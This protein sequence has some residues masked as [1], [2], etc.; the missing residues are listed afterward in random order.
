M[1]AL[2]AII[3]TFACTVDSV[4]TG[5]KLRTLISTTRGY[6][7]RAL[8]E[9]HSVVDEAKGMFNDQCFSINVRNLLNVDA[10][11]HCSTMEFKRAVCW[12][13]HVVAPLEE[14]LSKEVMD[15][16]IGTMLQAIDSVMELWTQFST[17]EL[18]CDCHRNISKVL[19]LIE[20]LRRIVQAGSA[21]K[22]RRKK[23]WREDFVLSSAEVLEAM[24]SLPNLAGDL[25]RDDISTSIAGVNST[26]S[27]A[28]I[29]SKLT[30][31][32]LLLLE[33]DS[34]LL[35]MFSRSKDVDLIPS[36]ALSCHSDYLRFYI[37]KTVRFKPHLVPLWVEFMRSCSLRERLIDQMLAN[38]DSTATWGE[39]CKL[40][41]LEQI[42]QVDILSNL[43][44]QL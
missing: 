41:R 43:T 5:T 10:Y 18:S 39:P 24:G 36:I 38:A 1:C 13:N 40:W 31:L 28:C 23:I 3:A 15:A 27:L 22:T 19:Q 14:P 37:S 21:N 6:R 20:L 12:F 8:P 29:V 2:L 25:I 33:Y 30:K 17:V 34:S 7:R 42:K 35:R 32:D 4:N 26:E 44:S 16:E 11:S 9:W